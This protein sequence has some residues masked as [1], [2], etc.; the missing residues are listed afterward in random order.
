LVRLTGLSVCLQEAGLTKVGRSQVVANMSLRHLKCEELTL[1][2]LL[3][4]RMSPQ[5]P[6]LSPCLSPAVR[7]TATCRRSASHLL[8][9]CLLRALLEPNSTT[10]TPA[11]DITNGQ[12]H[13]NSTTNLSHR[14]ARAQHLDMSRCWD[15]ANFCPLVVFVGGVRSWCS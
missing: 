7:T 5:P 15:V 13:N 9:V 1:V 11:T 10:R 2:L 8:F 6:Q 4:E 3:T 14:N 12:A